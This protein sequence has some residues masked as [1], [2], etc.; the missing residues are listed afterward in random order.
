MAVTEATPDEKQAES[1]PRKRALPVRRVITCVIV[2]A[3]LIVLPQIV[4]DRIFAGQ[5]V[6]E[7]AVLG[8]SLTEIN[9]ALVA[10][11]GAVALNLL[12][13]Q[14]GLVSLGHAAFF[15]L[16]AAMAAVTTQQLGLPFL[17]A[18]V[19]AGAAG[20]LVGI[21]VGLPSLRL[22]G[23]YL[24]LATLSLHY[25]ALY[26]F[27]EYQLAVFGPA[28]IP[29]DMP[30]IFGWELSSPNRWYFLL[31]SIVVVILTGLW[32]LERSRVGKSFLAVRDN[33][34]AAAALG[35]NVPWIRLTAFAVSSV[36]VS[37]A[38]ALY[39]FVIG[40]V[41][42]GSFTLPF[43]I[44]YF[45]MILLG[46]LG[47]TLGAVLGALVWTLLPS[48]FRLLA[49]SVDPATPVVGD[50][51]V[52]NQSQVIQIV[53]GITIILIL[54]FKPDGLAGLAKAIGRRLNRRDDSHV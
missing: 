47:S 40:Y 53:M 23:L 38:G 42:D 26:V 48:V 22:K 27:Q 21:V 24:M 44:G 34:V 4:D 14:A 51:L 50:L 33:P 18:L 10:I 11:I 17:A 45:A 43:M 13:G 30:V 35:M 9:V 6:Q 3:A 54:R 16:G 19:V 7:I 32:N 2:A 31:L 12:V 52:T 46:G 15:A 5:I 49:N 25:I 41:S 1:S 29:Y 39:A 20:G 37:V 8:I 28:G 36:M